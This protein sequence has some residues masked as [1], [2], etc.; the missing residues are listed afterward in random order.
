M[1][2]RRQREAFIAAH[3]DGSGLPEGRFQNV[4]DRSGKV[5]CVICHRDGWGSTA[6]LANMVGF[7]GR[8][9]RWSDRISPWQV[10]CLQDHPWPCSCGLSFRRFVDLWLHIGADRPAGWGRQ[11]VHEYSLECDLAVTA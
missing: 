3:R 7:D 8:L 9:W 1:S 2:S 11:G 5:W 6:P 4:S 10:D